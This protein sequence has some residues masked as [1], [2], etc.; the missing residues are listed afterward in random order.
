M[1]PCWT[2]Q[3]TNMGDPLLSQQPDSAAATAAHTSCG[4]FP[5]QHISY[6]SNVCMAL[7]IHPGNLLDA[8]AAAKNY[9]AATWLAS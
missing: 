1:W 8:V 4:R 2:R 7:T 6:H 3:A 5:F 9:T